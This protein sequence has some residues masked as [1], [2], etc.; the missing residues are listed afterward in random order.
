MSSAVAGIFGPRHG[1][2]LH[3]NQIREE[4]LSDNLTDFSPHPPRPDVAGGAAG[5]W[6]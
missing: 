2:F 6:G 3:T 1:A 4:P 5:R